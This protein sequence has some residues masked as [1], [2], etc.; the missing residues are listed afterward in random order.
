MIGHPHACKINIIKKSHY[1]K[2]NPN[3]GLET[4]FR[5]KN[6]PS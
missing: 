2:I 1:C 3:S 6:I 4:S 5:F